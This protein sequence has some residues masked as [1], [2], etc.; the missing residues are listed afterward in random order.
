MTAKRI[1]WRVILSITHGYRHSEL[2]VS[3]LDNE[4][5]DIVGCDTVYT[6]LSYT[7][8]LRLKVILSE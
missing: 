5:P 7:R 6:I 8:E 1:C 4:V 2:T 3:Y